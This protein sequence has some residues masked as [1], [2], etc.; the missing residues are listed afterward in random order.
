MFE[1]G[2]YMAR[3]CPKCGAIH[4]WKMYCKTAGCQVKGCAEARQRNHIRK[5][6]RVDFREDRQLVLMTLTLPSSSKEQVD[7][8]LYRQK[9]IRQ[10]KA[11]AKAL[12][13]E[14]YI[15]CHEI[16]VNP[17]RPIDSQYHYHHHLLIEMTLDQ[18]DNVIG[19]LHDRVCL[20]W[21]TITE[22]NLNWQYGV[23]V[24][25]VRESPGGRDWDQI[26]KYLTK[27]ITKY[28]K[29]Y[30]NQL[31]FP[32]G[33]Q[34]FQRIGPIINR[35]F[36][37][38][39]PQ[40]CTLEGKKVKDNKGVVEWSHDVSQNTS[41]LDVCVGNQ[42]NG[43]KRLDGTIIKPVVPKKVWIV[44]NTALSIL[45]TKK[46]KTMITKQCVHC[47]N[48]FRMNQSEDPW[49][50]LLEE[51]RAELVI[52]NQNVLERERQVCMQK[53]VSEEDPYT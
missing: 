35:Q 46:N 15:M 10:I 17:L 19:D 50:R 41:P 25:K 40:V 5:L 28:R 51:E 39:F 22:Q 11:L 12:N 43:Q 24:R 29:R 38:F 14:R 53:M 36:D 31:Y 20:I 6:L 4:S 44:R 30:S 2:S 18:H 16:T 45:E 3:A 27:Y 8:K 1:C 34:A 33:M 52:H 26:A 48:I 47:R 37:L 49:I 13:I 7:D 9:R 23:D 21:Q 42:W 32:K